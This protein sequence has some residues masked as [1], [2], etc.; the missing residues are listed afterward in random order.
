MTNQS[1]FI[2]TNQDSAFWT[3]ET[4]RIY[5]RMDYLGTQGRNISLYKSTLLFLLISTKECIS[6]AGAALSEPFF[7]RAISQPCY[8]PASAV[9]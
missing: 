8:F 9:S 3:N 4:V 6:L 2:P 5:I 7:L 1:D